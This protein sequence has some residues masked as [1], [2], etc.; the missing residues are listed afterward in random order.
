MSRSALAIL[1]TENLVDNLN[2][3]KSRA[4]K[5][6]VMAMVKANAFGHGLRS[7]AIRIEKH[8]DNLGVAS[9]D[10][11]LILR[12]IGIKCPVTLIEGIFE[13]DELLIAS[14]QKFD[15]VIHDFEQ[16]KWI[17]TNKIP[18]PV[19]VWLKLDSGMGRLGFKIDDIF[20]A[21]ERVKNTKN[22]NA[23]IGLMSHFGCADDPGHELNRIQLENFK[24]VAKYWEGSKS[25]ANS[26]GIFGIPESHYDVVRPGICMYGGSPIKGKLAKDF[27]LKPV[28]TLQT[29]LTAVREISSGSTIGYGATYLCEK[30]TKIGIIAIGYGDGY[31]RALPT[32]TPVLVNGIRCSTVGRISM[33]MTA[34][35]L[36]QCENAKVGDNVVLWG[37]WLPVEEVIKNTNLINHE[38]LCGV[39]ARVKFHWT[40]I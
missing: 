18:V 6:S 29:R 19:N 20:I 37:E 22:I 15:I 26:A 24:K 7:T 2:E 38:I 28:M 35:D 32:G 33:D 39:Q 1:S 17:E 11:A 14:C 40:M 21:L 34:I 25:I 10:E 16:I 30:D 3:I 36:S 4:P 23:N 12:N 27:G 5:S 31:S 8:V 13:P 9:I